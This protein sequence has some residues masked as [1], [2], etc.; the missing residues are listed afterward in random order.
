MSKIIVSYDGTA[1]DEDA[2]ALGRVLSGAGA[3][4][5]LAYVRHAASDDRD[6]EALD[7]KD[8]DQLLE[9]GARSFGAN[10]ADRRVIGN[11]STPD[12]LR[13][14]AEGEKADIV[15]F[16]SDA[17]TAAGSVQPQTSAQRLLN[18]GPAAVA[19]APAGFRSDSAK[20]EKIGVISEGGDKAAQET[21]ESL[22][23][24]LGVSVADAGE[25]ADLIVVGS[26]PD[27]QDGRVTLSAASEYAIET[28]NAPVLAV[29]R[30]KALK[31]AKRRLK[32]RS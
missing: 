17:H 30:G 6:Q 24:A 18:G 27:G 19:L 20:V 21:A 7:E 22:A 12:G 2:V 11:A 16:G 32:I 23:S 5:A 25:P 28:A 14:L 8:A 3:D 15:V 10:H 1:N 9:R 26:S 29:A 31:F 13:E 4:V